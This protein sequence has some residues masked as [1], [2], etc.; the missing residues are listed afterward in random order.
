[1]LSSPPTVSATQEVQPRFRASPP[2]LTQVGLLG[3]VVMGYWCAT[4]NIKNLNE[5]INVFTQTYQLPPA[6]VPLLRAAAAKEG[7]HFD[8]FC[9]VDNTNCTYAQRIQ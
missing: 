1:M 3:S 2:S 7:F 6:A 5:G 8:S 4:N 9:T